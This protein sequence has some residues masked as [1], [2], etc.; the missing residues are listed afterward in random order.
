M[1]SYTKLGPYCKL[2]ATCYP[3]IKD[4]SCNTGLNNLIISHVAMVAR[5][6]NNSMWKHFMTWPPTEFVQEGWPNCKGKQSQDWFV[7]YSA[8]E[9]V[10]VAVRR[11]ICTQ[12]VP[13]SNLGRVMGYSKCFNGYP[14][15]LQASTGA[16]FYP[17]DVGSIF[18]PKPLGEGTPRKLATA[19]QRNRNFR[20]LVSAWVQHMLLNGAAQIVETA[21][22]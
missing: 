13:D 12:E 16:V 22:P 17:K 15:S 21:L 19:T 6:P 4:I 10:E 14:R 8:T 3:L 5:L 18:L 9:E 11:L 1:Q 7:C 20:E 2:V